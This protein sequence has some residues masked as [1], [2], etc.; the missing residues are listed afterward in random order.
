MT[1]N[2]NNHVR[3][4]LTDLGRQIHRADY[5]DLVKLCGHV[6]YPY[7]PVAED[8]DGWSEWQAWCLMSLFGKHL[9]NGRPLPFETVI[10]IEAVEETATEPS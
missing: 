4:R 3:V 10:R 5:D 8:K 1:F 2:I 9:G 7:T 6:P